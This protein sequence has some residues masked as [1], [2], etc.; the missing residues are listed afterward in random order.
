MEI[1]DEWRRDELE[2]MDPKHAISA[3]SLDYLLFQERDKN[4]AWRGQ[5]EIVCEE[6]SGDKNAA[7]CQE[8]MEKAR[9]G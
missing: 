6:L 5:K 1:L 4:S 9:L 3:C 8:C 2:E 7:G